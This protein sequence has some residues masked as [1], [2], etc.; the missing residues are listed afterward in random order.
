M[1]DPKHIEEMELEE[2]E[3]E[4]DDAIEEQENNDDF[5]EDKMKLQIFET[6]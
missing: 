5:N 1:D 2:S 3:K 4:D 6:E